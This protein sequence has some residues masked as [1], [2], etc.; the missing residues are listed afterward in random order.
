MRRYRQHTD[1]LGSRR[2]AYMAI[3]GGISKSIAMKFLRIHPNIYHHLFT[4][5]AGSRLLFTNLHPKFPTIR[6]EQYLESLTLLHLLRNLTSIAC[7]GSNVS[8]T[9]CARPELP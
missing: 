2:N 4:L 8:T 7:F 3:Y 9:C 1:L 5:Q 6:S